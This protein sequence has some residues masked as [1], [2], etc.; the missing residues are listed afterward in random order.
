MLIVSIYLLVKYVNGAGTL[1][2]RAWE[3]KHWSLLLSFS[4][5]NRRETQYLVQLKGTLCRS[6]EK[7][8]FYCAKKIST[9][10]FWRNLC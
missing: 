1:G 4:P 7:I 6:R 9:R 10:T 5:P 2:L 3:K 8:P